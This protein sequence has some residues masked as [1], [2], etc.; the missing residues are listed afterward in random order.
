VIVNFTDEEVRVPLDGPW[1]VD[2]ASDGV[3]EGKPYSGAVAPSAALL[4]K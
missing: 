4:M 3:G 2:I 1:L